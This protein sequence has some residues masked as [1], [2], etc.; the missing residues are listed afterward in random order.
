MLLLIKMEYF[1][2]KAKLVDKG[3]MTKAPAAITYARIMAKETVRKALIITAFNDLD[4]MLG[5]IL[6]AYV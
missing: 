3:H 6:N 4:V 1:L 5:D 2:C